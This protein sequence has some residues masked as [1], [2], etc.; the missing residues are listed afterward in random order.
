MGRTFIFRKIS[1][2]MMFYDSIM[3]SFSFWTLCSFDVL[4]ILALNLNDC[5]RIPMSVKVKFAPKYSATL[6]LEGTSQQI[7]R[8]ILKFKFSWC[9][10]FDDIQLCP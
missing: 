6:E 9:T 7:V 10:Q 3:A 1:L 5:H 8:Q 2:C 4:F